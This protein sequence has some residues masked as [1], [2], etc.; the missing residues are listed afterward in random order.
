[1]VS[2]NVT[3]GQ[4]VAAS[5]QTPTLFLIA[6]DLKKM[7]VDTNVSE[8]DVGSLK[9]GD[10]ASFTVD[11]F[12]D[13]VFHGAVVQVRQS[14]QTVQNVVTYDVVVGTDNSDLAL[15]PGMTASTQI[16]IHRHND[17]LRVPDQALR[18]SPGNIPR[19]VAPGATQ[20]RIWILRDGNPVAVP[21]VT[22]LDDG[23]FSEIVEGDLRPGDAVITG[24]S[25]G[26]PQRS[27]ASPLARF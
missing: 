9:Q 21:V 12:P 6:T 5:F 26:Q 11:A 17:V 10:T 22:G 15:M 25:T 4:T 7:Q 14:P 8:S 24:E 19:S 20:A 18:Y 23:T 3:Q 13:R 27:P 2:R 1:M 16:V